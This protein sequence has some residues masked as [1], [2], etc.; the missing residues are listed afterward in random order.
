MQ[1]RG[2]SVDLV[3]VNTNGPWRNAVHREL[4]IVSLDGKR[5]ATIIPR[6]RRYLREQKPDIVVAALRHANVSLMLASVFMN[7][8]PKIILSERNDMWEELKGDLALTNKQDLSIWQKIGKAVS[9]RIEVLLVR[10]LYKRAD[11]IVAVSADAARSAERTLNLPSATVKVLYNPFDVKKKRAQSIEASEELWPNPSKVPTIV[12]VARLSPEKGHDVL[13]DAFAMVRRACSARLL[14]IGEGPEREAIRRRLVERGIQEHEY[15]MPGW[16]YNPIRVVAQCDLFVLSSR[17]EGL[18]GVLIEAMIAGVQII[19][20][21]CKSGPREILEGGRW[22]KL[23]P[24]DNPAALADAIIDT[25][26]RNDFDNK[27]IN[28]RA[29]FFDTKKVIDMWEAEILTV[30]ANE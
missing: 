17:F 16:I 26:R 3:L 22:G 7:A 11:R 27:T 28:E 30:L 1:G 4:N 5:T 14:L 12:S 9:R 24:V 25:I 23:I 8:K 2:Y 21:D 29:W 18:P 13:I 15:L 10:S 19:S 6:L 20:T